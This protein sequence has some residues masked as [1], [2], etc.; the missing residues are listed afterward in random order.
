MTGEP[1]GFSRVAAGISSFDG[2]FRFPLV[3]AQG[4]TVF[5]LSC[6]VELGIALESW[7][8]KNYLISAYVQD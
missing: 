5:L 7:Q 8:G 2:E 6:D 4:S 1:R 3:L